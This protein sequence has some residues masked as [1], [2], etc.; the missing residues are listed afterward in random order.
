MHNCYPP[1]WVCILCMPSLLVTVHWRGHPPCLG[2][3]T[4]PSPSAGWC[5][6]AQQLSMY[7][8]MY[9]SACRVQHARVV[10]TLYPQ[11]WVGILHYTLRGY[12]L[13]GRLVGAGCTQ[14]YSVYT[15]YTTILYVQNTLR[16]SCLLHSV[17]SVYCYPQQLYRSVDL[18]VPTASGW[19]SC[20]S[21]WWDHRTI[22]FLGCAH[23]H[24]RWLHS[25]SYSCSGCTHPPSPRWY[26]QRCG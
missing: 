16:P 26:M 24:P 25:V 19:S 17:A 6:A 5:I 14:T 8:Y 1:S 15:E 21:P 10:P 9:T 2:W 12:V 11:Q 13:I 18:H 3:A 20:S 23:N 22:H 4:Q 7:V